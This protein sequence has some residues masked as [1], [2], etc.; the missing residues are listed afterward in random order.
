MRAASFDEKMGNLFVL[1][2]LFL[3]FLLFCDPFG[4]FPGQRK[5]L[6]IVVKRDGGK[7][8]LDVVALFL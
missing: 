7:V 6:Q 2:C 5:E 3:S 1:F 8:A 4:P